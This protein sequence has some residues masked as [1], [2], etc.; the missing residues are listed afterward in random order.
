ATASFTQLDKGSSV[1]FNGQSITITNA[2]QGAFAITA[3]LPID[4]AG[5]LRAATS[6]AQFQEIAARLDVN[7]TRNQLVL[8]AKTAFY[9]ILRDQALVVV[10][11]QN[12]RLALDNLSDAQ[13]RLRAGTV[14]RFDV[15]RAESDVANA[16]QQLIQARSNVSLAIAIMNNTIGIDVNTPVQIS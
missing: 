9:N 5:L 7:R 12:L 2:S 4:I 10:A 6:Q 16:Q 15:I 8:D 11:T 14:A 13:K 3:S 1:N